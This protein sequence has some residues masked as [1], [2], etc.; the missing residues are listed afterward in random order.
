MQKHRS[1]AIPMFIVMCCVATSVVL[2][3]G[4]T[5]RTTKSSQGTGGVVISE[6]LG[7]EYDNQKNTF[8]TNVVGEDSSAIQGSG[9]QTLIVIKLNRRPNVEYK[10]ISRKLK[11][12]ALYEE[13]GK[14]DEIF[15][16]IELV[17]PLV[18]ATFFVPLI[19]QRGQLRQP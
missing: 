3:Q 2:A 1:L 17:V 12:T 5:Q 19:I 15:E 13:A 16:R 9:Q 8:S 6:I 11:V 18:E 4:K 14:Q 7:Y 10:Y